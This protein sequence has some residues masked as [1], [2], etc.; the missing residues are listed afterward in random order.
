MPALTLFLTSIA[1]KQHVYL[2]KKLIKK[3]F[4]TYFLSYVCLRLQLQQEQERTHVFA[5]T[6]ELQK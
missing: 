5:V 3:T 2:I 6:A 1:G 4:F